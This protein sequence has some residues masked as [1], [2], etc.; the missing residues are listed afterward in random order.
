M[1]PTPEF[2]KKKG[3]SPV[4]ILPIIALC[5]S[6]WIAYTSYQ[7]AGIGI[8]IFFDDAS[9]IT[10]GKTQIIY[11]GIPIGQI[12]QLE[13]DLDNRRIKALAEIDKTASGLLVEDTRFWIV[14]PEISAASVQGLDTLLS[15]SYIGIQ[16]GTS[17]DPEE[18]F[19]GLSSPPPIPAETPGLHVKL[20]AEELGSVQTGSGIYFR[21]IRIGSVTNV[22]LEQGNAFVIINIYIKPDY[23]HL[24]KEDSRFSKAGGINISGK[25]TNL[26]VQIESLASLLKGG[27]VLFTPEVFKDSKPAQNRQIFP[28]YENIE[29]AR[30]GIPMTLQLASSTG[31]TE[32]ETQ[33]IY[34]GLVAGIVEKIEFNEDER[35]SVTA[36]IMLDP[37]AEGILRSTTEFWIVRPEISLEGMEN[38]DTILSGPFITFLPGDGPFRRNFEILPEPPPLR[39][40]RP[41]SELLLSAAKSH[42]IN[43][44]APVKYKEKKVGEVL[45]VGFDDDFDKSEILIFIYE[46]YEELVQPT[47]VFWKEGGIAF[48]AGFSGVHLQTDSLNAVLNGG[49]SFIT[50]KAA[51]ATS[52]EK[53][54]NINFSVYESYAEAVRESPLLQSDG[55]HFQL[56]TDNPES[57]KVGTPLYYQKIEVGK[58]TGFRL[59]ED[60]HTTIIDCFLEKQYAGTVNS[61]SRFYNI[62]GITVKGSLSGFTVAAQ[63]LQSIVTGG[64]GF[65]TPQRNAIP[66]KNDIFPLYA[67]RSAAEDIDKI[68]VSVRFRES[69][70]LRKGSPVRY[71][72]VEIGYVSDLS[73]ADEMIDIIVKLS[74]DKEAESFFRSGTMI[75]TEKA[76][77]SLSGIRNLKNVL[78]GSYLSILPGSGNLSKEFIALSD[79][80]SITVENTAGL[81]VV[82]ESKHLGSLKIDSPVF[83]RQVKIGKV[84]G[85]KLSDTFRSVFIHLNI[86]DPYRPLI[87][88]NTKFWKASGARIEGGLFSGLSV[89]IESLEALLAG[90]IA[91]ATP[92]NSRMLSG[93]EKYHFTLHDQAEKEW[94]DWQ[95]EI[96]LVEGEE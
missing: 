80:P 88:E 6:G 75:W 52:P 17:S 37:R 63:S 46:Q 34:R 62:S 43:K 12:S 23:A 33:V 32:G 1:E 20:R 15:G 68:T 72:G 77:M 70:D 57:F 10:P 18:I 3:I 40:L 61:S 45:D 24:V 8:V 74:I 28:L 9:G 89:S 22:E 58:V 71:K 93:S 92:N 86:E 5:I 47:S 73:F 36:H 42:S 96:K 51:A 53:A 26:E 44:G 30:Y 82:L 35:H 54:D 60:N 21:N 11:R 87:R 14:K 90:G 55:Y 31:I 81:H 91:V 2:K 84:V 78:F 59:S 83:Y 69:G 85:Y 29:S 7:N 66:Q 39:P 16:P 94:L 27:I 48:D 4:W 67:D 79:P 41:G 64:I 65:F 76:E 49:I 38:L 19:T 50:P 13:P 56:K 95:P 25:L